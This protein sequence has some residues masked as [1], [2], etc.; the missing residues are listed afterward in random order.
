MVLCLDANCPTGDITCIMANC[1][2]FL[3]GLN[4]GSTIYTSFSSC[5]VC[6]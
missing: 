4:Q 1:S 5:P 3:A 6:P 2:S